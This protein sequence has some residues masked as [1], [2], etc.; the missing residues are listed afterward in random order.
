[1]GS[2]AGCVVA[3]LCRQLCGVCRD[4]RFVSP[5]LR[6]GWLQLLNLVHPQL[7]GLSGLTD[8]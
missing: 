5:G 4:E 6:R 7:R 8:A 1:M 2:N 3:M